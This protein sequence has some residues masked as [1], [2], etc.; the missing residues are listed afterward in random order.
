LILVPIHDDW[1]CARLLGAL[2]AQEALRGARV[3]QKAAAAAGVPLLGDRLD[4]ALARAL[5]TWQNG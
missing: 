2:D 4:F 3:L 1:E 5:Q